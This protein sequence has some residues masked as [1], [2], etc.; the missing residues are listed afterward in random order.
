MLI[1]TR[2][3]E[4]LVAGESHLEQGKVSCEVP[5]KVTTCTCI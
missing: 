1:L 2:V 4:I 5:N 3:S